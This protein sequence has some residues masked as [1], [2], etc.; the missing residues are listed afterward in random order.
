MFHNTDTYDKSKIRFIDKIIFFYW[1]MSEFGI[2][3]YV[4]LWHKNRMIW[5]EH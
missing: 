5:K 4:I 1:A 2:S 3:V